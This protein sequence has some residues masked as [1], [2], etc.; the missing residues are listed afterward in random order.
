MSSTNMIPEMPLTEHEMATLNA[1]K[2]IRTRQVDYK[3]AAV[4]KILAQLADSGCRVTVL[5][6]GYDGHDS[7]VTR[8]TRGENGKFI[9]A[10]CGT[11]GPEDVYSIWSDPSDDPIITIT[12][13]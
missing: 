10:L 1:A 8:I 7:I 11:C 6:P 2:V 13:D 5:K 3:T 12:L 4:A 9:I